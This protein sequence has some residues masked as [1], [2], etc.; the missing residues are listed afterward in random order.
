M[1]VGGPK[2][3]EIAARIGKALALSLGFLGLFGG[4]LV[5]FIVIFVYIAGAP[6]PR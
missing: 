2:A 6:K 4:Q 1:R 5:L 3:T